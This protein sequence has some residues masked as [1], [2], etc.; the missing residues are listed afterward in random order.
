MSYGVET[1]KEWLRM[2]LE[3]KH[4]EEGVLYNEVENNVVKEFI[5]YC[6]ES[7]SVDDLA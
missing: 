2:Y 3:K 1:Q 7:F 4:Q 5:N 6:V